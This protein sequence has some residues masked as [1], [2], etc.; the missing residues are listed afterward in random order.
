MATNTS[1]YCSECGQAFS[2]SEVVAV[3]G[4]NVCGPCKPGLLRR[5]Q[6]GA[7]QLAP[8]HYKGFWIRLLAKFLDNILLELVYTPFLF[9]AMIP[10]WRMT[11]QNPQPDP[12]QA[13]AMMAGM[14]GSFA[15][16]YVGMMALM[17]A[18]NTFMLGK[19]GTT[20]GK[21]A[22]GAKVVTPTGEKIGYGKALGRSAMELVNGFTLGIGYLIAAFD[23]Q[24]RGLHDHVA[25]TVVVA[26]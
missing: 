19:W 3:A 26:K 2:P 21:M 9:A 23:E 12:A 24:K 8:M 22:I 25:G 16:V 13:A 5:L 1:I 18:Y 17:L 20:M 4:A 15:L 6:E 7:V 11:I 10:F 14:F